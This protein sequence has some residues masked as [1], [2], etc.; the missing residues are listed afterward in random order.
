[1]VASDT[2]V[3]CHDIVEGSRDRKG[4]GCRIDSRM[5]LGV[6]SV[7]NDNQP[8]CLK[9][10]HSSWALSTEEDELEEDELDED[11]DDDAYVMIYKSVNSGAM[12]EEFFNDCSGQCPVS[13]DHI[14]TSI[15]MPTSHFL[16]ITSYLPVPLLSL[17]MKK[18]MLGQDKH[19][20]M[21]IQHQMIREV[22]SKLTRA[23]SV[24]ANSVDSSR[25]S[26]VNKL[27][28]PL[29]MKRKT[30]SAIY[31]GPLATIPHSVSV[32]SQDS[33][34]SY[35]QCIDEKTFTTGVYLDGPTEEHRGN[36]RKT[37]P[38][39]PGNVGTKIDIIA[40]DSKLI[41][42]FREATRYFCSLTI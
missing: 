23:G 25:H 38:N 5:D 16:T 19:L 1:M 42:L 2:V 30:N 33:V 39:R 10:D 21:K 36:V 20:D 9:E 41:S 17:K 11:E 18:Q 29:M 14:A 37:V 12:E 7:E 40:Y 6:V 22:T 28:S 24:R 32:E 27:R 31:P 13:T 35:A 26:S 15:P 3:L 8:L 4:R 34:Q